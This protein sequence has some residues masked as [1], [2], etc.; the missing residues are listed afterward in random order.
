MGAGK[1]LTESGKPR[2]KEDLSG[3]VVGDKALESARDAGE[4]DGLYSQV[5]E[6]HQ[7]S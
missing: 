3:L 2:F 5:K 1:Q 7:M 4:Q 6:S